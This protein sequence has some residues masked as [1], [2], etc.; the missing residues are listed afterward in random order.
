MPLISSRDSLPV[1]SIV[2]SNAAVL[3]V[4]CSVVDTDPQSY[5][6]STAAGPKMNAAAIRIDKSA[7]MTLV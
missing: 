3:K 1:P 4:L 7:P 6:Y 5:K 2:R